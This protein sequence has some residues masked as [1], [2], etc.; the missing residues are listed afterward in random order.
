[1][2]WTVGSAT[3]VSVHSPASTIFFRPVFSTA[4]TK[5]LSS[6]EFMD[7][8]STG[9]GLPRAASTWGQVLPLKDL[10]STVDRTNG[11][12]KTR[13][14]LARAIL[15]LMIVCRSKLATPK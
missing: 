8:R 11:T 13:V 7:V 14:A 2:A 10:V 3:Q 5:F 4:A 15:L 1:M 12:S 9:V 6:H